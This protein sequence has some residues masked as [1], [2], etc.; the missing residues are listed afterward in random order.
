MFAAWITEG[1]LV[2]DTEALSSAAFGAAGAAGQQQQGPADPVPAVR[3]DVALGERPSCMSVSEDNLHV[4]VALGDKVC[5]PPFRSVVF[6]AAA[7][8]AAA[9]T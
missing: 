1:V 7:A 9:S 8:A 2:Y 5:W 4:A 6:T 3:A